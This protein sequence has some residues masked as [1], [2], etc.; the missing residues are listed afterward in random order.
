MPTKL[1]N[2]LLFLLEK[3]ENLLHKRFSHFFNK[4]IT[5]YICNIYFQN[6]NETL[7]NDVVNFE[8][9]GPGVMFPTR[10][11]SNWHVQL[12]TLVRCLVFSSKHRGPVVQSIVI[13]T[14]SLRRQLV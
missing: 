8:Q 5:V 14:T 9:L 11:D 4:K 7:T 12:Q 13:L 10:H 6:F 1:S 3:C 2:T